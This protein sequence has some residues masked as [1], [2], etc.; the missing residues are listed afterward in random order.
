MSLSKAVK[1]LQTKIKE[2][3]GR[4]YQVAEPGSEINT[5]SILQ[6]TWNI[7][8]ILNIGSIPGIVTPGPKQDQFSLWCYHVLDMSTFTFRVIDE[9][10]NQLAKAII[11]CI[12]EITSDSGISTL[13]Y[14]SGQKKEILEVIATH[15]E[16]LENII[17]A[18]EENQRLIVTQKAR[19][20]A[21]LGN[22]IEPQL[23][24]SLNLI[25]ATSTLAHRINLDLNATRSKLNAAKTA[26]PATIRNVQAYISQLTH[27][28]ENIAEIVSE[29]K[30]FDDSLNLELIEAFSELVVRDERV[31]SLNRMAHQLLERLRLEEAEIDRALAPRAG[32]DPKLAT[33]R[34]L[35]DTLETL[36]SELDGAKAAHTQALANFSSIPKPE[37][38]SLDHLQAGAADRCAN[39]STNIRLLRHYVIEMDKKPHPLPTA[40]DL[41]SALE[42]GTDNTIE[43]HVTELLTSAQEALDERARR[44]RTL[45]ILK[46]SMLIGP[47]D[48][49]SRDALKSI[50]ESKIDQLINESAITDIR[51]PPATAD[52]TTLVAPNTLF[53]FRNHYLTRQSWEI[54]KQRIDASY[55]LLKKTEMKHKQAS[56]DL[57]L[58]RLEFNLE[59]IAEEKDALHVILTSVHEMTDADE[60]LRILEAN[61]TDIERIT[62]W[63]S[64]VS[65]PTTQTNEAL[66]TEFKRSFAD[67][68]T[69]YASFQA[70]HRSLS[71]PIPEEFNE[72][73]AALSSKAADIST[74]YNALSQLK[75]DLAEQKIS[76]GL[77]KLATIEVAIDSALTSAP[78]RSSFAL[79]ATQDI[80][81]SDDDLPPIPPLQTIRERRPALGIQK[82]ALIEIEIYHQLKEHFFGSEPETVGGVFGQYLQERSNTH[83]IQDFFESC[84]S[85]L[86]SCLGY[87]S[88]ATKTKDYLKS[89]KS[90]ANIDNT[91]EHSALQAGIQ[92]G[93][94]LF[95]PKRFSNKGSILLT[96]LGEL[97][98]ALNASAVAA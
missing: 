39:I 56:L 91:P 96:K 69:M 38:L 17:Q 37:A 53:D 8:S 48:R 78:T 92:S 54:E 24:A 41:I 42:C 57:L 52:T 85:F 30:G 70:L 72:K 60:A 95:S 65:A 93:L 15:K 46:T 16:G 28:R 25:T 2:L 79:T 3:G 33:I 9:K 26:F 89:L 81:G 22:H 13:L 84:L 14:M 73:M 67:I 40:S 45:G 75:T 35:D 50:I 77:Q 44:K 55:L 21:A 58:A 19:I 11:P 10:T 27:Y 71:Q 76:R 87:K 66:F 63:F 23:P 47:E 36:S 4:E 88:E 34:C 49:R 20:V 61:K 64:A 5:E 74:T 68:Q 18:Y 94:I 51:I 29:L 83:V 59:N 1:T 12:D 31:L 80:A 7:I 82:I 32:E 43:Q 98:S 62:A 90:Q 6:A 97:Q 86:F